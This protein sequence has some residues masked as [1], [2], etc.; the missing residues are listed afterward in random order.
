MSASLTPEGDVPKDFDWDEWFAITPKNR[1]NL[2]AGDLAGGDILYRFEFWH[3]KG[4][5]VMRHGKEWWQKSVAQL[6]HETGLTYDVV[7]T[8]IALMKKRGMIVTHQFKVMHKCPEQGQTVMHFRLTRKARRLLFRAPTMEFPV[9]PGGPTQ[10]GSESTTQD[11]SQNA[12]QGAL[13]GATPKINKGHIHKVYV[14]PNGKTEPSLK[15]ASGMMLKEILAGGKP[16]PQKSKPASL[17]VAWLKATANGQFQAPLLNKDKAQLK[18]FAK[19][20][21]PGREVEIIEKVVD[22]WTEFCEKAKH[23]G[24]FN[25]PAKPALGFM[26]HQAKV[27]IPFALTKLDGKKP[28]SKHKPVQLIAPGPQGPTSGEATPEQPDTGLSGFDD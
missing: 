17:D 25:V 1:Y 28:A 19:Q 26:L 9:D 20:C 21:P 12:T 23:Q 3:R 22:C 24:A 7:R 13:G 14:L 4:K 2:I 10:V 16:K 8:R 5:P 6:M 18:T 11:A 27:A 15:V